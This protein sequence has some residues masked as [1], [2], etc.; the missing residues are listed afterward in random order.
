MKF[1]IASPWRNKVIVEGLV[2]ELTKRGYDA[3]SF[4]E[5]GANLLTGISIAEELKTFS[6]AVRNWQDNSDIK[7]IFDTELAGLK[8]S[9]IIILLEPTGHSSLIEAGIGYGMGKKVVIIGQAE[10]PEVFYLISEKLYPDIASFL[11]DLGRIA[12]K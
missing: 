2:E 7:R 12:P 4:L 10:K 6:E 9:D 8:A 3:Y 11:A 1:F 5:N